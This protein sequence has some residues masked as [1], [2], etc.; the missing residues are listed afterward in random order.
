MVT[1]SHSKGFTYLGLLFALALAGVGLAAAGAV[2]HTAG[3]R[4]KEEQLLFAGDAIS[5]AIARYY[6]RTP[7]GV[8]EFP[9]TLQDL[10][11][12]R[13]YIT[14]ERHLRKIYADPITGKSTWGLIKS[15]DGRIVGVYSPSRETP[16]K[17][18]NFRDAFAAFA[19]AEH[20]SEWRFTAVN[21]QT[22]SSV[23]AIPS[24]A[25]GDASP[26]AKRR[27]PDSGK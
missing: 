24:A 3:K 7:D 12:D 18:D 4:A 14:V 5:N 25:N 2:W 20:Y 19:H 27:P 1:P 26:A 9:R 13:R 17:Q 16:L 6:R 21:T 15:A 22:T 8:R 23:D 10:V 11:E